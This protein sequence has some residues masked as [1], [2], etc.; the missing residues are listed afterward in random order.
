MAIRRRIVLAVV[1]G[2][3]FLATLGV[4][5]TY[6]IWYLKGGAY[7]TDEEVS[8]TFEK[9]VESGVIAVPDPAARRRAQGELWAASMAAT[10]N[11][12][13]D[14]TGASVAALLAGAALLITAW[15]PWRAAR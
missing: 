9:L 10:E 15:P 12:F 7:H 14:G 11:G 6:F 3:A 1:I 5:G 4:R 8:S 2:T 13:G